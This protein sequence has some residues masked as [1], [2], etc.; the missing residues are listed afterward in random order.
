MG[1]HYNAVNTFTVYKNMN[2]FDDVSEFPVAFDWGSRTVSLSLSASVTDADAQR[3]V[4]AV[5]SS[6][7]Y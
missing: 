6:L 4:D 2:L 3:V 5:K 1:V 7:T